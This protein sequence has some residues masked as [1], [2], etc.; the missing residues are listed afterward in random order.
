MLDFRDGRWKGFGLV[1]QPLVLRLSFHACGFRFIPY[2]KASA[3]KDAGFQGASSWVKELL[4]IRFQ[5]I[6]TQVHMNYILY[7]I[8][9]YTRTYYIM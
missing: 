4:P 8:V 5:P 3:V 2:M 9:I 1:V 7:N 6:S